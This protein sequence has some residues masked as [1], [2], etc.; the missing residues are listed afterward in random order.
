M[1]AS[2]PRDPEHLTRA[3]LDEFL[4]LFTHEIRNRLNGISLESADLAEQVGDA[5]DATRLQQ[6][7]RDC[8]AYLKSVRALLTPDDADAPPLS[9]AEILARLREMKKG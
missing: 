3:E 8:A 2:A 4:H 5:A 9:V 7:V 6:S 1:N